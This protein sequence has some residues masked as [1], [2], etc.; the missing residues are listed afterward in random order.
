M[1]PTG[2]PT[3]GNTAPSQKGALREAEL[4]ENVILHRDPMTKLFLTCLLALASPVSGADWHVLP[5]GA[6]QEDGTSWEHAFGPSVLA[7]LDGD[8]LKPGDR[9]LIGSG[10]YRDVSVGV[11]CSGRDDAPITI[12]GVDRGDGLPRFV[13]DW[14]IER[15][16]KGPTAVRIEPGVSHVTVGHLRIESHQ[17]GV[18]ANPGESRRHL[19]FEKIDIRQARHGFYLSDCDDLTLADCGVRRYSK[20]A[21]RFDQGCDRVKVSRCTADCSEGDAAWEG[22][23]ELL[24]FGFIVNSSG[25]PNTAFVFEDCLARN[26]LMPKQDGKYKNGDGFVV[27]DNARDVQFIRC[28]ALDNEDGGFD[29]KVPDVRLTGCVATG[30]GRNFR[31]WTTATLDNCFSGWAGTGLWC[32]GGPVKVSK[33][34]FHALSGQAILTDDKAREPVTLT[35]CLLSGVAQIHRKTSKGT[36]VIDDSN[37]VDDSADGAGAGYVAPSEDWDGLG[38][39]MDSRLAPEKGYRHDR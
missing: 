17:Y 13:S 22:L 26:N 6:G 29:L 14:T 36:V 28:R 5:K 18:L 3:A 2:F 9:L 32:N 8:L 10:D 11:A 39:A 33:S 7:K 19:G 16:D 4:L 12:T 35:D 21:F 34:T 37:V 25:A 23:T 20:H 1:E 27:E 15:P 38:D 30:N 31:I 24:P